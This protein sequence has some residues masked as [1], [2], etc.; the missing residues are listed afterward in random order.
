MD[1]IKT[2]TSQSNR[3]YE[4]TSSFSGQE[5]I[6]VLDESVQN[7]AKQVFD[8]TPL[9]ESSG[10]LADDYQD[11]G[12]SFVE[13]ETLKLTESIFSEQKEKALEESKENPFQEEL[14]SKREHLGQFLEKGDVNN[15]QWSPKA[16][17]TMGSKFE[18][19]ED[20]ELLYFL[21]WIHNNP[22]ASDKEIQEQ[23]DQLS[24]NCNTNTFLGLS[25]MRG[26]SEKQLSPRA[27]LR[28]HLK[29]TGAI[30]FAT[31]LG[32]NDVDHKLNKEPDTEIPKGT[33][34]F[35]VP[36]Y[37]QTQKKTPF[38]HVFFA[39]QNGKNSDKI[40][41]SLNEGQQSSELQS[42]AEVLGQGSYNEMNSKLV[43]SKKYRD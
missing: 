36:Y 27:E 16:S 28:A 34:V 22:K 37:E 30:N 26:M 25:K 17:I 11:L 42:L 15:K 21:R 23:L 2:N 20:P 29:E 7:V 5:K 10:H 41:R 32:I 12:P 33:V 39:E 3:M 38:L 43:F 14:I 35:V 1:K 18:S 24:Q 13:K 19:H 6:S 9:M 31:V 8:Q 40:Y 4:E